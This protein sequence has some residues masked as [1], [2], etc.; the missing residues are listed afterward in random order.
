M[1]KIPVT[2]WLERE[3]VEILDRLCEKDGYRVKTRS[4]LLREI[5]V[6]FIRRASQT[7]EG[8]LLGG[9]E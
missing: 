3:I 9:G 5:I 6:D 8:K 7:Q 2:V 1:R 4:T